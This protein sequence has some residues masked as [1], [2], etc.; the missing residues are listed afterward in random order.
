M[1]K[2]LFLAVLLITS[3][4][5]NP[6]PDYTGRYLGWLVFQNPETGRVHNG[7]VMVNVEKINDSLFVTSTTP[8]Y[9]IDS[10]GIGFGIEQSTDTVINYEGVFLNDST[11]TNVIKDT[12]FIYRTK[13]EEI[14]LGEGRLSYTVS[15]ETVTDTVK[16]FSVGNGELIKIKQ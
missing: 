13:T 2:V 4:N 10:Y 6:E 9:S 15:S 7:Q 5:L 8:K 14:V 16:T 11:F 12:T 3:C 1:K